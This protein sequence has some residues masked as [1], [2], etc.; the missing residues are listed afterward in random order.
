MVSEGAR[1]YIETLLDSAQDGS[2]AQK[3][4]K[5]INEALNVELLKE[6][7]PKGVQGVPLSEEPFMNKPCVS[8]KA[9]RENVDQVLQSLIGKIN[10]QFEG[11]DICE[12]YEDYDYDENDVSEYRSVGSVSDIIQMIEECRRRGR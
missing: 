7:A 12:Y 9:C 5:E 11:Y 6:V 2:Y 1:R 10:E 3:W 4:L 8:E